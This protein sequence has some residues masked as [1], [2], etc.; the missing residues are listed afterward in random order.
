MSCW[1]SSGGGPAG[2]AVDRCR[3][4]GYPGVVPRFPRT[5]RTIR[6]PLHKVIGRTGP[7]RAD[8]PWIAEPESVE[9]RACHRLGCPHESRAVSFVRALGRIV[10]WNPSNVPSGVNM[11]AAGLAVAFDEPGS[12]ECVADGD[13]LLGHLS[14]GG[15]TRT[16][17]SLRARSCVDPSRSGWRTR[18]STPRPV[19]SAISGTRSSG[20]RQ[21]SPMTCEVQRR[22]GGR[23]KEPITCEVRRSSPRWPTSRRRCWRSCGRSPSRPRPTAPRWT[24]YV[25]LAQR[26]IELHR[27]QAAAAAGDRARISELFDNRLDLTHRIDATLGFECMIRLGA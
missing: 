17:S 11:A 23:R 24:R 13:V 18:P 20:R 3:R 5:P 2:P 6:R 25:P 21:T 9:R 16:S 12:Y 1:E 22:S 4:S 27:E 26:M 15:A 7:V 19:G 10:G 8:R 14:S